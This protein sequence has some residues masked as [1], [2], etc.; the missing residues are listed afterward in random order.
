MF[1]QNEKYKVGISLSSASIES[2]G[3][4]I[5]NPGNR[6]LD[7]L[8]KSYVI[9][10]SSTDTEYQLAI[11]GSYLSSEHDCASLE[12]SLLTLLLNNSIHR[13]DLRSGSLIQYK[14]VPGFDCGFGLYR[15]TDGYILYGEMEILMIAPDL[16]VKWRYSGRDIFVSMDNSNAFEMREDGIYLQDFEGNKYV[17][18]YE[19][20]TLDYI[21]FAKQNREVS[22]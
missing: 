4:R 1:L 20:N 22:I 7:E 18:S 17:V 21:P 14:E 2:K 11:I 15:I 8:S 6:A 10:V 5:L 13:I 19:G 16:T 3:G 9:Q 12:G